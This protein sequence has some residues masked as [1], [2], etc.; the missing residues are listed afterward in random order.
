MRR[1]GTGPGGRRVPACPLTFV[2]EAVEPRRMLAA[3]DLDPSFG[4]DG[5]ALTFLP[6]TS[7]RGVDVAVQADGKT[8]VAGWAGAAES[9]ALTRYNLNGTPDTTFGPDHNG[10]ITGF[11]GGRADGV[12]IQPDGKIVVVASYLSSDSRVIRF[13]PDGGLD[14]TFGG[15]DGSVVFA[16][17]GGGR[18]SVFQ[19]VIILPDGKI[20]LGGYAVAGDG[21]FNFAFVRLGPDGS[22][23]D[24]FDGDGKKVLDFGGSE[25]FSAM[26]I[27][28]SG[29]PATNPKYGSIVV[30]GYYNGAS[31][32]EALIMTRLTPD[33]AHDTTYDGDGISVVPYPTGDLIVPVGVVVQDDGRAVVGGYVGN[34]VYFLVRFGH[35]GPID[36]TFGPQQT[37]WVETRVG[38]AYTIASDMMKA[39]SGGFIL[40]GHI[41]VDD[42]S[43]NALAFYTPDGRLDERFAGTGKII[44]SIGSGGSLAAGPGRRFVVAG[45]PNMDAARFFDVGAN[46]VYAA[47]LNSTASESGPT[48]RGFFVY[49]LERLPVATRVYFDVGGTAAAPRIPRDERDYTSEGLVFPIR[50]PGIDPTPYVDIPANATFAVA[51]I[52]PV[53]DAVAEGNETAVFTI[54]PN[55]N[56]EV[57][58]PRT[59][60]LTIVDNDAPP[61]SVA[62]VYARGSAWKGTDG[63]ALNTTFKESLAS[64]GLG[65]AEFGYRV[66]NLPA[67]ATLPWVNV[68]QLVLRYTAPPTGAGIPTAGGVTLD[69][70]RSDY[71]VASVEQ[72]DPRT[73]LLTLDR[74]LGTPPGGAGGSDGDRVVVSV[75]GGNAGATYTLALNTLQGDADRTF[76][77]VNA[78][79]LAFAKSRQNRTATEVPPA[80]GAYSPFADV[81]ADGRVNAVDLASVKARLNAAMPV[82]AGAPAPPSDKQLISQLVLG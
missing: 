55:A 71:A 25:F 44:H 15:G 67:A 52:T 54:R 33:G 8:V 57:G 68:N 60:T 77:R 12:A 73:Y 32:D 5:R 11:P 4:G 40:T 79:D 45:G 27:D 16:A 17:V 49:R 28:Y 10:T 62:Q 63:D 18:T 7:L 9:V 51:T 24:S 43:R 35:D 37:G 48:A 6:G 29:T 42:Q 41:R 58:D 50:F 82:A 80:S 69:G 56:Y 19:N 36:P 78:A 2:C 81:N 72:L 64:R 70:A 1:C 66:D 38:P 61:P 47:T 34:S 20:L 13:N 22:F 59:V 21:N 31:V 65:D 39:P 23:D 74:A 14:R 3:G 76:G 75:P 30:A 46:L 26:A 53:D